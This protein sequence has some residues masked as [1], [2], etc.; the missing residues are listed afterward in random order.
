MTQ[1]LSRGNNG[2]DD[3]NIGCARSRTG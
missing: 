1:V 2:Y 3:S